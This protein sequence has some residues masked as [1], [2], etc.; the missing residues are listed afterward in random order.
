MQRFVV[1]LL[2]VLVGLCTS[3]ACAATYTCDT[4]STCSDVLGAAAEGDT[5]QLIA[6]LSAESTYCIDFSNRNGLVFDG[7]GH[8]ITKGEGGY[9]ALYLGSS[10]NTGNT[11]RDVQ[12]HGFTRGVYIV[13][14]SDNS[15]EDSVFTANGTGIALYSASANSF[16]HNLIQQNGIGVNLL[17]DSDDN[18]LSANSF[19]RN[20][21][22]GV[23]FSLRQDVGDP[24]GN[25]IYNN[26]FRNYGT[27]DLDIVL[28]SSEADRDISGVEFIL[29]LEQNCEGGGNV[30]GCG[31]M[32]G[33]YYQKPDGLGFSETCSDSDEDGI[34]DVQYTLVDA[35]DNG[36]AQLIDYAPLTVPP[37][38]CCTVGDRDGDG[39]IAASCGGDDF[40]D[41]PLR[42]GATCY[43]GAPE[44][45]DNLDNDGDGKKDDTV[46]CEDA[47]FPLEATLPQRLADQACVESPGD[48]LIYCFGGR[49]YSSPR[50]VDTITSYNPE[51]DVLTTLDA[52]L[53]LGRSGLSCSY[54]VS[55]AKIYCFGGYTQQ[56]VCYEWDEYGGCIGA[57]TYVQRLAEIVEF[58]PATGGVSALDTDLPTPLEG[59]SSAWNEASE[60][61]FILGGTSSV[62]AGNS[63][64]I[65]E[66]VPVGETLAT[67]PAILPTP[68]YNMSCSSDSERNRIY[69]FGGIGVD[70]KLDAIV[71]YNPQSDTVQPMNS[72]LPE[73]IVNMSCVE[74]SVD[75]IIYCSGGLGAASSGR[76]SILAYQPS[77]DTLT[78]QAS[79]MVRGRFGHACAQQAS[80]NRI[81]CFGG[82]KNVVTY[83][84]ILKYVPYMPPRGDVNDDGVVGLADVITSL[85]VVTDGQQTGV[86]RKADIGG[87][88]KIDLSEAVYLMRKISGS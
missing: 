16:V 72:S 55:T 75:H 13:R 41:D 3:L 49:A 77:T 26:I 22:A 51:N 6:D 47:L 27:R 64:A 44:V 86:N 80:T 60:S 29:N 48:G 83:R 69:C 67:R 78:E 17:W 54:A 31:C 79:R 24:E 73:G 53:P 23:S 12:V 81:F 45:C 65:L 20:E 68:R 76:D 28:S 57:S 37:A 14:G 62:H 25:M 88:R 32:G 71:E 33:N 38:G 4:C 39:H 19:V 18:I 43:P 52:S 85:K 50:Y 11:I 10:S 56:S 63:D 82:M 46:R 87:E 70:G 84:E 35:T 2:A 61:I 8:L 66:F 42:G 21:T 15:V 58:D 34:C 5:V 40:N 59:M 36:T 74:D 1:L 9:C 30:I 7:G